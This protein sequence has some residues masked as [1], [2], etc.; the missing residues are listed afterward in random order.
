[1]KYQ[2]TITISLPIDRVVALW[3]DESHFEQW[4]DGFQSIELLSGNK[5][6]KGAQSKII[7]EGPTRIELIETILVADLPREKIG[8]YEHKH[9][10]NT[11]TTRFRA[12]DNHTTEY[13]SEVE[14]TQFNG[15]MIKL[16]VWL[17][18]SKFKAQSKKWMEQ[19][20]MFSESYS[21][22]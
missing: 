10:V 12:I 8:K 2:C 14:Y 16:M 15:I 9:M 6:T 1:M 4:Q 20:K 21:E 13:I 18:P 22:A 3:Q 17:F 19:F 7:L 11:Q 5:N